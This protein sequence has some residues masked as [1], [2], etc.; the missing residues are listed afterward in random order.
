M[1]VAQRLLYDG[2]S[3]FI[4]RFGLHVHPLRFVESRQVVEA[5]GCIR[6][7]RPQCLLSDGESAFGER[8]GLRVLPLLDISV[9]RSYFV[10]APAAKAMIRTITITASFNHPQLLTAL[11]SLSAWARERWASMTAGKSFRRFSSISC[12]APDR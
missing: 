11:R 4:E 8:F 3:A 6:M 9:L 1:F 10:T 7:I 5:M 2:D 12:L